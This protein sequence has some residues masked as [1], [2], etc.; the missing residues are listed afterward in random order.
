LGA[1]QSWTFHST[2]YVNGPATLIVAR[3]GLMHFGSVGYGDWRWNGGAV[4]THWNAGGIR[5]ARFRQQSAGQD[6]L[7]DIPYWPFI[8]I[9]GSLAVTSAI[10]ARRKREF[11]KN[12][13]CE[14]CGYDLRATP[15]RC[16][17]CGMVPK[18]TEAAV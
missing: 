5:Y 8:L 11:L 17:E 1:A 2:T 12:G 14:R 15:D 10:F 4:A 7:L 18:K 6:W 16:P 13:H 9:T 3:R